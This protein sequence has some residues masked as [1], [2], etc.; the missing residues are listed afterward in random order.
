MPQMVFPRV[1]LI[2]QLDP[3]SN[4]SFAIS[5]FNEFKYREP[6]HY[7]QPLFALHITRDSS[8]HI[9][10]RISSL[11]TYTTSLISVFRICADENYKVPWLFVG[12][13][14]KYN[15]NFKFLYSLFQIIY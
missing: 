7:Y 12:T 3:I 13:S 10:F 2:L 1:R 6:R 14:V 11:I 15:F 4:I 9:L 5:S 8:H